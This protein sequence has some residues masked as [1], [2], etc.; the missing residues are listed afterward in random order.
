MNK[1]RVVQN[2]SAVPACL[3]TGCHLKL[4]SSSAKPNAQT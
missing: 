2:S 1:S 4:K 3:L